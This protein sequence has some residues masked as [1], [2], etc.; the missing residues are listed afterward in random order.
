VLY[1]IAAIGAG[2]ATPEQK[3]SKRRVRPTHLFVGVEQLCMDF[4]C[5]EYAPYARCFGNQ[6]FR[7]FEVD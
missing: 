7:V 6:G 3:F 2:L 5:A 1:A 4:I